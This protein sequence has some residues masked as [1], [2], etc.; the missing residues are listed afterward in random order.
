M[1]VNFSHHAG[2]I[3]KSTCLS[4]NVY[5]DKLIDIVDVDKL[6]HDLATFILVHLRMI[7]NQAKRKQLNKQSKNISR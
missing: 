4:V 2:T 3:L 1:R 5:V 6:S 7:S